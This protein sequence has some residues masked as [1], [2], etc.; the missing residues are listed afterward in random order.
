MFF[1]VFADAQRL[2]CRSQRS[3]Y[4]EANIAASVS[5]EE[6]GEGGPAKHGRARQTISDKRVNL[7][8]PGSSPAALRKKSTMSVRT[9]LLY[10]KNLQTLIEESVSMSI[11][12]TIILNSSCRDIGY[13]RSPSGYSDLSDCSRA[14]AGVSRSSV[15]FCVQLLGQL[16]VQTLRNGVL[17]L[18]L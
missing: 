18:E 15:M 2:R 10:K 14:S 4:S 12:N 16:H 1:S 5:D 6:G 3:N 11:M 17:R 13:S 8:I 9:A 7:V